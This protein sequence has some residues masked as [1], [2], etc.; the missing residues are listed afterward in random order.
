MGHERVLIRIIYPS[1]FYVILE[2][3]R[4]R[5]IH[6]HYL[7]GHGKTLRTHTLM[8]A[9]S[10]INILYRQIW[11]ETRVIKKAMN[12]FLKLS[13]FTHDAKVLDFFLFS[14]SSWLKLHSTNLSQIFWKLLYL[15]TKYKTA[16]FIIAAISAVWDVGLPWAPE[17][18]FKD[19]AKFYRLAKNTWFNQVQI[20][21]DVVPD[22]ENLF[23][24]LTKRYLMK[25][26]SRTVMF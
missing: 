4:S 1:H 6:H 15:Q 13:N 25:S 9:L 17:R 14:W 18:L 11:R 26:I 22:L 20:Y 5:S 7:H 12:L 19:P 24:K 10:H 2:E 21:Y 16:N 8:C 3:R 23:Q